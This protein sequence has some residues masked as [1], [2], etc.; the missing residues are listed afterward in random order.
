MAI[1][2][3]VV[4]GVA[5]KATEAAKVPRLKGYLKDVHQAVGIPPNAPSTTRIDAV[6]TAVSRAEKLPAVEEE[7][8]KLSS[9]VTDHNTKLC[10]ALG[11]GVGN[12]D[13]LE[14]IWQLVD[15]KAHKTTGFTANELKS[16]KMQIGKDGNLARACKVMRSKVQLK[17]FCNMLDKVTP[18]TEF[19]PD[20]GRY[21]SR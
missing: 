14:A 12:A 4:Q 10:D 6:R 1:G 16:V 8:E 2:E 13:Q 5:L 21:N 18:D 7:Y 11:C 20:K 17:A 19:T 9:Q 3:R 15:T